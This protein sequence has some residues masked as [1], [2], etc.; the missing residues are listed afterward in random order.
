[1]SIHSDKSGAVYPRSGSDRSEPKGSNLTMQRNKPSGNI[2][3][4]WT[5]VWRKERD[6]NPR[7]L[8]HHTISNRARSTTP[9]SLQALVLYTKIFRCAIKSFLILIFFDIIVKI[10]RDKK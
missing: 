9:T 10:K 8:S 2:F 7:M 3:L 6:L 5:Y 4:N 1:M